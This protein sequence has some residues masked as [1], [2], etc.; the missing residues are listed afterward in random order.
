MTQLTGI[1]GF[2][3]EYVQLTLVIVLAGLALKWLY[4]EVTG[5]NYYKKYPIGKAMDDLAKSGELKGKD[6]TKAI[7]EV[8]HSANRQFQAGQF[9]QNIRNQ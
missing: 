9:T 2:L 4:N 5:K 3:M 6:V 8:D 1:T 7:M